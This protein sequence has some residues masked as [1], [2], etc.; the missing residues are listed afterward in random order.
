MK[1]NSLIIIVGVLIF[2]ANIIFAQVNLVISEFMASNQ[3]SLL[4]ESGASSDWVEIYNPNS[5]E[6]NLEGWFLTDN[7][8]KLTKWEFPS[9]NMSPYSFMIVFCSGKNRQ[10]PGQ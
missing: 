9:T 2:T 6:V 8:N 5:F 1:R 4:D 3:R 7:A 10:T